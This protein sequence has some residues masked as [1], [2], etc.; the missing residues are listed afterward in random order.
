MTP[1]EHEDA[2][3]VLPGATGDEEAARLRREYPRWVVLWLDRE[4]QYRAGP[5]FR[6]PRGSVASAATP[7]EL[8]ARMDQIEAAARS[9][10]DSAPD[11]GTAAADVAA[12][13]RDS[14]L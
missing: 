1:E 10:R 11:T 13:R 8:A 4:G 7:A 12:S 5:L 9:P 6:A 3:G 2:S 14:D